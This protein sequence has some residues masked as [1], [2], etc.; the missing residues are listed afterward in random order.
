MRKFWSG[1]G[2]ITLVLFG[3]FLFRPAPAVADEIFVADHL[4]DLWRFSSNVPNRLRLGEL[5]APMVG[6]TFGPEGELLGLSSR[7]GIW[8]LDPETGQGEKLM[9]ELSS[10]D[11]EYRDLVQT[12]AETIYLLRWPLN[13]IFPE[14]T[15]LDLT[16]GL[17]EVLT[18]ITPPGFPEPIHVYSMID[19]GPGRLWLMDDR[20]IY[21]LDL[22]DLSTVD[23]VSSTVAGEYPEIAAYGMA[24]DSTDSLW[25]LS[26]W[27]GAQRGPYLL[28]ADL[29]E[30]GYEFTPESRPRALAMREDSGC[31]EDAETLC[32]QSRDLRAPV[33][34][35]SSKVQG[36]W[37]RGAGLLLDV[38]EPAIGPVT[39][40]EIFLVDQHKLWRLETE[41]ESQ[42]EIGVLAIDVVDLTFTPEGEL[43]ALTEDT[44]IYRVDPE[45]ATTT[46]VSPALS[47]APYVFPNL[48]VLPD[49]T[50]FVV[51]GYQMARF[52]AATGA[53]SNLWFHAVPEA[54]R[55]SLIDT[56]AVF[57]GVLVALGVIHEN[58]NRSPHLF[59]VGENGAAAVPLQAWA[60]PANRFFLDFDHDSE[61]NF[62]VR[63]NES[64]VI[65][66]P[67]VFPSTL[68][69]F[70]PETGL[71]V[72]KPTYTFT[73]PSPIPF[74]VRRSGP[75][76]LCRDSRNSLCFNTAT[77]AETWS[78]MPRSSP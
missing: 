60:W 11:F 15:R 55:H 9:P 43:W 37:V 62:W 45:T 3:V 54:G 39:G 31:V 48:L 61:G 51:E 38:A 12:D 16:S 8:R 47:E 35:S 30:P 46:L 76:I 44:A 71:A 26:E 78:A 27:I 65:G 13:I 56:L 70:D 21:E 20:S 17:E 2:C 52:D 73:S 66:L 14:V 36:E 59:G 63:W 72:Q 1:L 32:F 41:F 4:G 25:V 10:V 33:P 68:S 28:R 77:K 6:L 19:G 58:S 50:I 23:L 5:P 67:D 29:S 22:N 24:L 75:T 18:F 53:L 42:T 7:R 57:D 69:A 34:R 64:G 40:D 74:A 49:S